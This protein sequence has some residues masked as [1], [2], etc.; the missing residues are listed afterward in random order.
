[1]PG[2]QRD[3]VALAYVGGFTAGDIAAARGV[4]IGTAKSRVRLGLEKLRASLATAA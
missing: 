3:A 4:P 2:E 1:L